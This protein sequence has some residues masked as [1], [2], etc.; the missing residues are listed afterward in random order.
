MNTSA[1]DVESQIANFRPTP[2]EVIG[3]IAP[4]VLEDH[5][6]AI[7]RRRNSVGRAPRRRPSSGSIRSRSMIMGSDTPSPLRISAV[8]TME[9]DAKGQVTVG[10][11]RLL[12]SSNVTDVCFNRESELGC[13]TSG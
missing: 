5:R 8:V 1:T 3:G 10:E 12:L 11:C 4:H 2:R 6:F 7:R 9:E 13:D